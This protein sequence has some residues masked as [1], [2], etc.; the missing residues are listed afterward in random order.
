[1]PDEGIEIRGT[2]D[3]RYGKMLISAIIPTFRRPDSLAA[4]LECLE[5]QTLP[6]EKFE[7]IVAD[8]NGDTATR[9]LVRKKFPWVRWAK[10]PRSGPAAN[11]N[12]GASLAKGE[13]VAFV[14]DDC[15]PA[16][17]WLNAI[18][19][20]AD[21]DVIEGKTVCPDARD[22]PFQ[23]RAENLRGGAYWSCNLAVRRFVFERMGGFDED[24]LEAAG[25]DTEFAWRIAKQNLHTRF[26]AAA[27]VERPPRAMT[28]KEIWRRTWV[29]RWM[30]LYRLKTGQT[31][32]LRT[33][34]ITVIV[35]ASKR[36]IAGL[37]RTSLLFFM[38]FD[39]KLWR[40]NLFNQSWKW[41]TF[42]LVLPWVLMWEIRFRIA[43]RRAWSK[44]NS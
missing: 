29:A 11:R 40:T 24:F 4:C 35:S 25:G 13:W 31:A 20:Q 32:P 26:V 42:P 5:R 30:V 43:L 38:E 27:L 22:T 17:G 15:L 39:P 10:G 19:T 14:D 41:L 16:A 33:S 21:V 37:L 6:R 1:M 2:H 12:H 3:R 36:E 28:W 34:W 8:D 9:D 23:E 18:G 44:S 7:V